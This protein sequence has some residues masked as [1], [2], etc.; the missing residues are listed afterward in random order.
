MI[1][2]NFHHFHP[3]IYTFAN[4]CL[5]GGLVE[6]WWRSGGGMWRYVEV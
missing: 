4:S 2:L 5:G 1:V 6:V 3:N